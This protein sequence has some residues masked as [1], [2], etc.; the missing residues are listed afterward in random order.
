MGSGRDRADGDESGVPVP[1][2]RVLKVG[3]DDSKRR[4]ND[5]EEEDKTHHN[6]YIH[7][8][9]ALLAGESNALNPGPGPDPNLAPATHSLSP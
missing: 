9:R 2:S 4:N 8:P 1:T 5:D 3:A 6:A 7:F